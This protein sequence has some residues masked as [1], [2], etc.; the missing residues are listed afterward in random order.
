MLKFM[1]LM[2]QVFYQ[3][4][5]ETGEITDTS[6]IPDDIGVEGAPTSEGG[7]G[8]G[9]GPTIGEAEKSLAD[10]DESAWDEQGNK[11]PHYLANLH[12]FPFE[13]GY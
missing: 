5:I 11:P 4:D 10:L 6:G 1:N 2:P 7:D 12:V 9:A 8:S 3:A 13:L